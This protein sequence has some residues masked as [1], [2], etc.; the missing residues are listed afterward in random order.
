MDF[1][2]APLPYDYDAL[3]PYLSAR[4]LHFHYN[5]HHATYLNQ[6]EQA[7]GGSVQ[8]EHSLE[9]IIAESDGNIFNLAAQVWN[10]DFFWQS[11]RPGGGGSPFTTLADRLK[12]DFGSVA[13]FKQRFAEAARGE[14]GSGWA[15][16]VRDPDGSLRVLS[17]T[18]ADNPVATGLGPLLTIDV[19]EH[20]YYLDYQNERG[21]YIEAFLDHLIDWHAVAER[22]TAMQESLMTVEG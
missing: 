11:M 19:W 18:D 10:H 16:L 13:N 22:M 21:K 20:A 8:A 2:L 5:R 1:Q 15:W 6:L 12:Q 7:I 14:F 4:T 17:T 9:E 3:E